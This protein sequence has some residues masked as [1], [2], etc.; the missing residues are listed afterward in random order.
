M[1][2]DE[3]HVRIRSLDASCHNGEWPYNVE[4]PLCKNPRAYNGE[5]TT[6][7]ISEIPMHTVGTFLIFERV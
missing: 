2:Q 6:Q 5:S 1:G 4:S 3:L 7:L